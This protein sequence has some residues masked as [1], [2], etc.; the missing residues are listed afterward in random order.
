[1]RTCTS[2]TLVF[3]F[4]SIQVGAKIKNGYETEINN[5]K[6]SLKALLAMLDNAPSLLPSERRAVRVSIEHVV[7]YIVYYELTELLLEQF[8]AISPRPILSA[9]NLH[10][11][12]KKTVSPSHCISRRHHWH[13][14]WLSRL[15]NRIVLEAHPVGVLMPCASALYIYNALLAQQHVWATILYA[16]PSPSINIVHYSGVA[17]CIT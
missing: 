8:K 11:C 6:E 13:H 2:F 16:K 15:N 14:Q 9:V 4:L 3:I 5:S 1:M 12:K 17:I 7:D 10:L